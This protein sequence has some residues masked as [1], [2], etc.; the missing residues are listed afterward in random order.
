MAT[1]KL[2]TTQRSAIA[3]EAGKFRRSVKAKYEGAVLT[4][5]EEA[6]KAKVKLREE[7][8]ATKSEAL[9]VGLGSIGAGVVASQV[10]REFKIKRDRG[11][12]AM[13]IN[14]GG[15]AVG[16]AMTYYAR[17]NQSGMRIAGG[18]LVGLAVAQVALQM[19]EKDL[20]PGYNE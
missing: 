8:K 12:L 9:M 14:Y 20:V 17:P 15:A 2:S 18:A 6:A 11:A 7:H 4:A 5:K 3:E 16:M 1:T 19:Q 13:G 10:H